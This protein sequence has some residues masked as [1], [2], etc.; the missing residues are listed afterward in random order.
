[1]NASPSVC[2]GRVN[3]GAQQVR[4]PAVAA[5][6]A[7]LQRLFAWRWWLPPASSAELEVWIAD[8]GEEYGP[9]LSFGEAFRS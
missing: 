7:V 9:T 8:D 3:E 4:T 1:M 2:A 5:K 6:L